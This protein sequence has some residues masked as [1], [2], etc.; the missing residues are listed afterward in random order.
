MEVEWEGVGGRENVK[1]GGNYKMLYI[2]AGP[3]EQLPEYNRIRG[4]MYWA[5]T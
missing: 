1:D 2:F 5:R 4:N 3:I